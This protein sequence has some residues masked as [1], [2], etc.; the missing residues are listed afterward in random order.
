[1]GLYIPR[2]L[3]SES[4][5]SYYN[6]I[7]LL[8]GKMPLLFID[9]NLGRDKGMQRI[10]IYEDDNPMLIAEK[11]CLNHGLNESKQKKLQ[12]MVSLKMKEHKE[13]LRQN[14]Y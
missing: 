7:I 8:L 14:N 6:Y 3:N 9:V 1:M 10:I 12:E 13:K 2:H 11:F 4:I 5:V